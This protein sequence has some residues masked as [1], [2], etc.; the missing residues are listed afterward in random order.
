MKKPRPVLVLGDL[1]LDEASTEVVVAVLDGACEIALERGAKAF[2]QLGDVGTNKRN[3]PTKA[4]SRLQDSVARWADYGLE[5]HWIAGNHDQPDRAL[6]G[7]DAL[8]VLAGVPV[9]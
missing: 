8:R 5:S 4:M 6:T 7:H 9:V 1:H 2:I 3:V